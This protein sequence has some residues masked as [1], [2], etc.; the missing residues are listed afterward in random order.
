MR[1]ISYVKFCIIQARHRYHITTAHD[2]YTLYNDFVSVNDDNHLCSAKLTETIEA[3]R[4][5]YNV[6][7]ER[8]LGGVYDIDYFEARALECIKNAV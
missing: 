8:L 6:I 3:I 7:F 5:N 1:K 2:L 4:D